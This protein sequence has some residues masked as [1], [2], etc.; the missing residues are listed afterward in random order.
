V[1]EAVHRAFPDALIS[2]DTWRAAVAAE[3]VNFGARLVN[4]IG[5]ALYFVKG[6]MFV[7]FLYVIFLGL[8]LNGWRSWHRTR[9]A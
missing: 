5:I 4:D 7:S 6:V 8:A 2:V 9:T 3:A 1:I